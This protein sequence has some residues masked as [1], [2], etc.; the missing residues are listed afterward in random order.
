MAGAWLDFHQEVKRLWD[1]VIRSQAP[2][3]EHPFLLWGRFN[4]CKAYRA[5]GR[6]SLGPLESSAKVSRQVVVLSSSL[7][8]IHHLAES[9]WWGA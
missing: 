2:K 1:W 5:S 4:D 6:D 8:T 3:V 7:G 9:L